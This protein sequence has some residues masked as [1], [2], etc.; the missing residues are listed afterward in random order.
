MF[1]STFHFSRYKNQILIKAPVR[2]I[3]KKKKLTKDFFQ[4]FPDFSLPSIVLQNAI[5]YIGHHAHKGD[6][7]DIMLPYLSM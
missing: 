6:M 3:P 4:T 5:T 7:M 2:V 1:S